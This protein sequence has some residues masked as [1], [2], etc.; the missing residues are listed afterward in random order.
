[1]Y[2]HNLHFQFLNFDLN[3]KLDTYYIYQYNYKMS[4]RGY[5]E[6]LMTPSNHKD[7][8]GMS[9]KAFDTHFKTLNNGLLSVARNLSG[10]HTKVGELEVATKSANDLRHRVDTMEKTL[11]AHGKVLADIRGMLSDMSRSQQAPPNTTPQV[12]AQFMAQA[13]AAQLQKNRAQLMAEAQK[14][15]AENKTTKVKV[16]QE[17]K[18]DPVVVAAQENINEAVE[19]LL[20]NIPIEPANS[21]NLDQILESANKNLDNTNSVLK[22]KSDS[23]SDTEPDDESDNGS[24]KNIEISDEEP[25]AM[26]ESKPK[27][28]D[29]ALPKPKPTSKP[30]PA[31]KAV[32][33]RIVSQKKK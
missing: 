18:S 30:A 5:N 23:G 19:D 7:S 20:K 3:Y 29:V 4:S 32:P 13:T 14:M 21:Q 16:E 15:Q 27:K 2:I 9:L 25:P 24:D 1:M 11:A 22:E 26:S 8:S 28:E 10:M 12:P 33:R 6:T 17:T 31:S